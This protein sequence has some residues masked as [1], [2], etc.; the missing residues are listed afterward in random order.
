MIGESDGLTNTWYLGQKEGTGWQIDLIV[1][2]GDDY[3]IDL[4]GL[5]PENLRRR[6]AQLAAMVVGYLAESAALAAVDRL[7][8][9]T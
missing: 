3:G 2:Y 4:S 6:I 5:T 1:R 7:E 8:E 9:F